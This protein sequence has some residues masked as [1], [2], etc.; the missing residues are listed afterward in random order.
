[1]KIKIKGVQKLKKD[2]KKAL[3]EL[4]KIAAVE[5]RDMVEKNLEPSKDTGALQKSFKIKLRAKGAIVY[6]DLPYALIQ[7]QG[8]KIRITDKMRKKMWAL[9]KDTKLPLY[10]SIA[11]TKKT[12]VTIPAKNY[13]TVNQRELS[14]KIDRKLN[15]LLSRV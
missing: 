11:I 2:L 13:T 4:P 1:M 9:Y 14:K 10:K 6:S 5:Y 12:S 7:D 8:G 15:K 3:K